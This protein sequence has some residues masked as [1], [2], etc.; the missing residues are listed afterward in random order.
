MPNWEEYYGTYD[1]DELNER[2]H[3]DCVNASRAEDEEYE[4]LQRL[5]A[6]SDSTELHK[7]DNDINSSEKSNEQIL[8]EDDE[9]IPF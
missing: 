8:E 4:R 7:N 3:E 1:P 2:F 9:E 5:L 6:N